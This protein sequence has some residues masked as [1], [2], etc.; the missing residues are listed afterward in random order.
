MANN[1][2]LNLGS[3]GD[4]I[5]DI[6]LANFAS[7]GYPTVTGK[8]P[9]TVLYVSQAVGTSPTACTTANALPVSQQGALPAGAN[10]IGTVVLGAGTAAAGT[11]ALGAGTAAVGTVTTN[12]DAPVGAGTAPSKS[13]LVAGVYN[14]TAPAPTTGQTMGLQ[15]NSAGSLLVSGEGLKTTYSASTGSFVPV[16]SATDIAILPGSATKTIKVL[17]VKVQL[18]STSTTSQNIACAL[19]KR[20]TANSGGTSSATTVVPHD[21]NNTAGSAVPLSYT[22]NPTTGTSIGNIDSAFVCTLDAPTIATPAD[23]MNEWVVDFTAPG[24]QPVVLRGT[25]QG[26]AVNLGGVTVTATAAAK[27]SYTYTEE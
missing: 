14:T 11:V 13:F 6:D 17:R 24:M 3:G 20:S 16:A 2:V 4:T 8:L 9:A 10:S 12:A 23:P 21:S 18:S 25:A 26:L 5:V 27:V 15:T 1:T 19:I 7:F 22:A